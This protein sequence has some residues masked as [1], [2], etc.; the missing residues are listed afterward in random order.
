MCGVTGRRPGGPA[1]D[2]V[3]K[4]EGGP[5]GSLRVA[6]KLGYIAGRH[7][8]GGSRTTEVQNK[9]LSTLGIAMMIGF[10]L[11]AIFKI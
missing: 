2:D 10:A 1:P 11:G 5:S 3:Q 9:P 7:M 6:L 4:S 8:L